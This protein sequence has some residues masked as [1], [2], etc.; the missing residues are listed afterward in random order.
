MSMYKDG[1]LGFV[2]HYESIFGT[3]I[4]DASA[5]AG[6]GVGAGVSSNRKIRLLYRAKP[7]SHVL[8][9]RSD[10]PHNLISMSRR[11]LSR[12]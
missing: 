6:V 4:I 3:V 2:M 11:E 9:I 8:W 7:T 10:T 12:W 5:H 1:G